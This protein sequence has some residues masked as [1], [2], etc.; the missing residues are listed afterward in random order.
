MATINPSMAVLA[1][2]RACVIIHEH[3]RKAKED[4]LVSD[5]AMYYYSLII[6]ERSSF[7]YIVS[8][9]RMNMERSKVRVSS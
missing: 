8:A 4:K 5:V 9:N 7:P 2:F 6:I 1:L 3:H